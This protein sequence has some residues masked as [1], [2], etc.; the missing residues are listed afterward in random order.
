MNKYLNT[1]YLI[2]AAVGTAFNAFIGGWDGMVQALI[3]FMALD[4]I[5]GFLAAIKNK[6]VDSHVM[7]W[8]GVNKFIVLAMVGIGVL[9]DRLTGFND[10]YI[11]TVVIWFYIGREGI[12][13][14]ENAS[15]LGLPVPDI[16]KSALEQLK[17]KG[18]VDV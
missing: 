3:W 14:L 6:N 17:D 11:R 8:G 15:K 4:F 9:L 5:F 7:F 18:D 2:I 1:I 12:S 13:I 16:V 10:P